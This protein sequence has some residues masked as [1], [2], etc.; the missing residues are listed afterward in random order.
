MLHGFPELAFLNKKSRKNIWLSPHCLN[1]KNR[2]NHREMHF[3]CYPIDLSTVNKKKNNSHS[4]EIVLILKTRSWEVKK[5]YIPAL[6]CLQ[7]QCKLKILNYCIYQII[8]L[9]I[10][11]VF[12]CENENQIIEIEQ[13]PFKMSQSY[14]KFMNRYIYIK[15]TVTKV[16]LAKLSVRLKVRIASIKGISHNRLV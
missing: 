11:N 4:F 2:V 7:N 14:P 9:L 10:F 12:Y 1:K 6:Y 15:F 16:T 5:F 13:I 8:D 3:C